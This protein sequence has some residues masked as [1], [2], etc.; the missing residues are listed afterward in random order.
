VSDH[1]AGRGLGRPGGPKW[2][3]LTPRYCD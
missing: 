2:W 3:S 1:L